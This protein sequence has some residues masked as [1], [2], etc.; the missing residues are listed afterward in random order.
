MLQN[1]VIKEKKAI[2]ILRVSS[3]E[4][5]RRGTSLES[6]EEWMKRTA[7][8][9]NLKLVKVIKDIISG[10]AFSK[11]YF[12][13]IIS[14]IKKENARYILVYS[15]DR[16]SRNLPYGAFL[17]ERLHEIG[18]VQIITSTGIFDLNNRNDRE[19]IW[20]SLL[21]AEKEQGSRE[22]RTSRGMVTK[23]K[24]GEWPLPPPFGYEI[25]DGR[26]RLIQGYESIII[27]I[28]ETFI[29]TRSYTQ[30]ARLTNERY[31][32]QMGFELNARRVK[33]IIHN[34]TY[35][36]Y[37]RWNGMLFGEGDENKPIKDLKIIDKKT[38]E[39]A[40][41][42]AS[43]INQ[44]YSKGNNE[45]IVK[46][47]EEYGM[48]N[49][50]EILNLKPACPKCGSHN[51]QRNGKEE[52]QLKFICKEC[53]HQ[54]RLPSKKQMKKLKEKSLFLCPKCGS[55]DITIREED[56]FLEIKCKNCGY[57]Q[58]YHRYVIKREFIKGK[59]YK[60]RQ[61]KQIT[62]DRAE[63]SLKNYL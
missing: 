39:R 20:Y 38:F 62:G 52:G 63:I 41:A 34:K 16:L 50:L 48:E 36:G 45:I 6:Q 27:F 15:F 30:T 22:E 56:D 37:L 58:L 2:G 11:K 60:R 61:S 18:K 46:L 5:A 53:S 10:E 14:S 8:Q 42:V 9:M 12:D 59:K 28:F 29:K 4:Q 33:K 49:T 7:Q 21:W 23:L 35:L 54:F 44:K 51:V 3:D 24:R 26:L 55:A 47:I 43:R 32:K 31:G 25:V 13:E 40:Q 19:Q 17:L 1:K 57:L